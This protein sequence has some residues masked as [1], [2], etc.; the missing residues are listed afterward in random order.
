MTT[1]PRDR[2]KKRL[3]EAAG[4]EFAE[5]GFEKATV[6]GI[7]ERADAN[8]AAVNYHFGDK[9]QLY[10]RTVIEAHRCEMEEP[11]GAMDAISGVDEPRE[12]LKLFIGH[13]LKRVLAV[14]EEQSW[15]QTIMLRELLRPTQASETLVREII[16]PKFDF[17]KGLLHKICPE[18]DD[19]RLN[20]LAFSVVGQC[21]HYK[22]ARNFMQKLIGA[23]EFAKLDADFLTDH[24]T[25][26]SLAALGIVPPLDASGGSNAREPVEATARGSES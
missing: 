7:C 17:L 9:E 22:T 26:F 4:E 23:S 21:M 14:Q 3:L 11:E 10:A 24:I 8:I 13:F 20:A 5:K 16:R 2:T 15:H 6:R 12:Q 18:A 19:R 1:I 25:T